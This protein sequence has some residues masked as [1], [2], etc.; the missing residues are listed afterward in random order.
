MSTPITRFLNALD[1]TASGYALRWRDGV[2]RVSYPMIPE[3]VIEI[4]ID[5]SWITRR[6]RNETTAMTTK[7]P[8]NVSD[9]YI[10][11]LAQQCRTYLEN[12]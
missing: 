9:E 12:L 3:N 5:G 8:G 11:L 10:A 1:P 7:L 2:L 4:N 6:K